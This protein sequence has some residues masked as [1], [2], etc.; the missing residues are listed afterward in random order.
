MPVAFLEGNIYIFYNL[1]QHDTKLENNQKKK[2]NENTNLK[3][4]IVSRMQKYTQR[5]LYA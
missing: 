1:L 3:N 5:N 2:N 4:I